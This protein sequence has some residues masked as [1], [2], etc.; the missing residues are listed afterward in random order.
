MKGE[1]NML[2]MQAQGLSIMVGFYVFENFMAYKS[3]VYSSTSGTK[4]GGHA[5]AIIGYGAESGI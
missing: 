5:T 2:K 4:K 1:A 3:G